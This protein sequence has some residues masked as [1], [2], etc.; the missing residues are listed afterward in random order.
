MGRGSS[1][2]RK[3]AQDQL[4]MENAWRK[5]QRAD[6]KYNRAQLMPHVQEQ[7]NSEG[8]D[9]AT[10]AAMTGASMEAGDAA[11][12]SAREGMVNQAAKTRNEGSLFANLANL[13]QARMDQKASTAR[14]LTKTFADEKQRRRDNGLKMMASIYGID[15]NLLGG[16]AGLSNQALGQHAAGISKIGFGLG[17]LSMSSG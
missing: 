11:Y 9:P 14:D 13:G 15:T 10:Q 4:N 17:P 16:T 12:G 2:Q 3:M 1:D 7:L 8:Y 6:Q 5:E